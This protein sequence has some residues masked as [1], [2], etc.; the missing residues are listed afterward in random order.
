MQS[1]FG[2]I[3]LPKENDFQEIEGARLFMDGDLYWIEIPFDLH[4][5]EKYNIITGAFTGFGIVT[6]LEC[7]VKKTSMGAGGH[8]GHLSVKY[9]LQGIQIDNEEDLFF[10]KL[11]VKMPSLR[12]W[13]NKRIFNQVNIFEDKLSLF[14]HEAISFGSFDKFTL[15]VSFYLNQSMNVETGLSVTDY[16]TLNIKSNDGNLRLWQF[17]EIYKKFK[18]FLAFL[19]AYDSK[20]DYFTFY[21]NEIKFDNQEILVP[22]KFFMKSYNFK[23]F[24]FDT[25]KTPKFDDIATDSEKILQNWFSIIDLSDSIDLILEKYFQSV[26]SVDSYFLNSCFAIEIYHRRFKKNERYSKAEFRKIKKS[27]LDKIDDP[28]ANVFFKEKLAH[29]N[30][31]SFKERLESLKEDFLLILPESEE[32]T[33][34]IKKIVKTR[35]YI[36][37]RSSSEGTI[38]DLEL[39]YA[40]IYL[41]LITK[42]SIFKELG[43]SQLHISTIFSSTRKKIEDMYHLNKRLQSG[44]ND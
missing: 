25:I 2:H 16:V 10:S 32:V 34:F 29:A 21:N 44:I 27:I 22:M 4:A 1:Y 35:N 15:E 33:G 23:N 3:Y 43:F 36:V 12:G 42:L 5:T 38:S 30:E 9:I 14:R 31:P 39:Y 20:E 8:E 41:E 17:I 37:H 26:L 19:G 18:K 40:S 6:L 11:S 13:L 28:V 24:G 7:T